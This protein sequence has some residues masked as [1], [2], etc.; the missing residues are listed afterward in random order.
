VRTP[1]R[2][3]LSLAVT[4]AITNL[5]LAVYNT[6]L[7]LYV[8]VFI[9]EY[10]ILTLLNSPLYPKVQKITDLFGY[11]LFG[12]FIVIVALKVLDILGGA[13]LL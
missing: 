5:V 8:S 2:Y 9:V 7:D 1:E 6:G 3:V 12:V 11:A 13:S 10:F 4:Y